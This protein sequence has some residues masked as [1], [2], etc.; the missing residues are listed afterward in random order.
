MAIELR[1]KMTKLT[2]TQAA[3]ALSA[4]YQEVVGVVPS[5]AILNLLVAQWAIETSEG[6][7]VHNFNFG[8][9][10]RSEDDEYWQT[11]PATEVVN[12]KTIHKTM[13]WAAYKTAAEGAAAYIRKLQEKDHWWA[14]LQTENVQLFNRALA[15]APVYYTAN[16][17]DYLNGLKRRISLYGK[18]TAPYAAEAQIGSEGR[19]P[20]AH[21]DELVL[22]TNPE[23]LRNAFD[24]VV[25]KTDPFGFGAEQVGGE[26]GVPSYSLTEPINL[27]IDKIVKSISP[28]PAKKHAWYH[29]LTFGL[30]GAETASKIPAIVPIPPRMRRAKKGEITKT[31]LAFID[32]AKRDAM[33]IGK[34]QSTV[35]TE[36]DPKTKKVV[37]RL[38]IAQTEWHND[39]L[40]TGGKGPKYWHPGISILVPTNK[41]LN[42]KPITAISGEADFGVD[43][44]FM[45]AF[46]D[47]GDEFGGRRRG[48]KR[49]GKQ[50]NRPRPAVIAIRSASAPVP[51]APTV[52]AAPPADIQPPVDITVAPIEDT[53]PLIDAPVDDV[54]AE[55]GSIEFG[56]GEN[57]LKVG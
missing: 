45:G 56:A 30:F 48:S 21:L 3:Q 35:I 54:G 40:E 24:V 7:N 6:K 23:R 13:Q 10:K 20:M 9:I 19:Y 11:F 27:A 4:G 36:T 43:S 17:N 52:S 14:G 5:Q 51:T 32:I 33:P 37:S 29:W 41:L 55:F 47:V 53:L 26:G 57:G 39:N 38:I 49:G 50:R 28:E 2:P 12:G 46:A 31:V 15:S 44:E 22:M 18:M 1:N 42:L 8:N 34:L 16:T 25:P